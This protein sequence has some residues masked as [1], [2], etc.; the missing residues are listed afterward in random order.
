MSIDCGSVVRKDGITIEVNDSSLKGRKEVNKISG[1]NCEVSPRVP[2]IYKYIYTYN[3][4][5]FLYISVWIEH[6]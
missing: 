1:Y 5:T 2:T 6:L 3:L 4:Y